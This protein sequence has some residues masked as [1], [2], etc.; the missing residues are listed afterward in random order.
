MKD[1]EVVSTRCFFCG[2]TAKKKIRWFSL[3]PK[4]HMCLAFCPEHGYFRGKARLKRTDEGK[5][6]VVKTVKKITEEE[7]EEVRQKRMC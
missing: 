3:N 1:R 6:Y 7:A 4:T 2:K 5:Y